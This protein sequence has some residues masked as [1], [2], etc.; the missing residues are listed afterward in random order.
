MLTLIRFFNFALQG[1]IDEL[2]C[3]QQLTTNH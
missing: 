2:I 3:F 1:R